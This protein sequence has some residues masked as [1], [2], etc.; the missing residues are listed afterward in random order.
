V[1]AKAA[2]RADEIWHR[3]VPKAVLKAKRIVKKIIGRK[4]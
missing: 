4:I 3:D 1:P 2:M